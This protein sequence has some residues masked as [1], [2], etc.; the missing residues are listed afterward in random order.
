MRVSRRG[1]VDDLAQDT[2]LQAWRR[3]GSYRAEGPFG[4][5]LLRIAW[6]TFLQAVRSH[7]QEHKLDAAAYHDT[8]QWHSEPPG[9]RMDI[10]RALAELPER[11]RAAV[12]LVLG[13]RHSHAEAA[14]ILRLPLGTL[15]STLLRA[16]RR[17]QQLLRDADDE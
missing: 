3:I 11:E 4:A 5:W 16:Q 15:K 9:V 8:Y 1:D 6:T 13:H 7:R 2:F 10:E 17:L 14:A 12:I